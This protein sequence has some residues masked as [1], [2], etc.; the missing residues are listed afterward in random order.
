MVEQCFNQN[1]TEADGQTHKRTIWARQSGKLWSF[2]R[3]SVT[4][5]FGLCQLETIENN[6]LDYLDGAGGS[7][8]QKA[9]RNGLYVAGLTDRLSRHRT[10]ILQYIC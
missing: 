10:F 7:G 2:S 5:K 6:N 1:Q 8:H 4:N 3:L 9:V